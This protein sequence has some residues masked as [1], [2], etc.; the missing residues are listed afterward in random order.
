VSIISSDPL[1]QLLTPF[2]SFR[3]FAFRDELIGF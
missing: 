3:I 2:C 1:L